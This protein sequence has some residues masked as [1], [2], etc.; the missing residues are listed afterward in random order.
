MLQD[1]VHRGGVAPELVPA[2]DQR[3]GLGHAHE[4][5]GPVERGVAPAHD[6]HPL[7]WL[8]RVVPVLVLALKMDQRLAHGTSLAAVLPTAGM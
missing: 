4:V 3:D 5:H 1:L 7:A 6:E 2:V 8:H